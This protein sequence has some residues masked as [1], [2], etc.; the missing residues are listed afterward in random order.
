MP[1]LLFQGS[2]LYPSLN[3]HTEPPLRRLSALCS[4]LRGKLAALL[5]RSVRVALSRL[6]STQPVAEVILTPLSP[7]A[8]V[9]LC[10][11]PRWSPPDEAWPP[12]DPSS[13]A[14][15]EPLVKVP[16]ALRPVEGC[17]H[18][19]LHISHKCVPAR[20]EPLP[21]WSPRQKCFR[22]ER[23]GRPLKRSL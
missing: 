2:P 8:L 12:F 17:V 14:T 22:H 10:S 6:T 9:P 18:V 23:P 19:S 7:P 21:A 15:S 1:V 11:V 3:R 5:E 20:H 16:S 4:E 13:L